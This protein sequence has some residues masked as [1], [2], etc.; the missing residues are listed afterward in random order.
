MQ[1]EAAA[2][3]R[4]RKDAHH[5][6]PQH[7]FFRLSLLIWLVWFADVLICLL[8]ASILNNATCLTLY[9]SFLGAASACIYATNIFLCI[10]F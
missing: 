4:G 1:G 5:E 6:G 8:C 2:G 10:K 9:F 7:Q 3:S